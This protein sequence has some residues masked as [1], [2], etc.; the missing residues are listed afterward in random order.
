MKNPFAL[1]VVGMLVASGC[2]VVQVHAPPGTQVAVSGRTVQVEETSASPAKSKPS[3]PSE[4]KAP[5]VAADADPNDAQ[6][7]ARRA[8]ELGQAEKNDEAIALYEQ[9]LKLKADEA[10]VWYN[11]GVLCIKAGRMER[12]MEVYGELEK[13]DE[14]RAQKL[15]AVLASLPAQ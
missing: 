6:A 1:V 12:A 14:Q 2:T 15:A 4:A 3:K 13:L 5:A 7:L 11:L 9:S 8:Y 10:W